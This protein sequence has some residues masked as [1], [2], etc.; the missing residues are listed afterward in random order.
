MSLDHEFI[1]AQ[2]KGSQKL[3]IML[4]G[5]GDS[6]EGFR[7]LPEAMNLP[8]MNY[9]LV[10]A[11]DAYYGGFSWFNFGGDIVPGVQRSRA[12]LGELLDTQRAKGFPTE[13]TILGG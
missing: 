11:P 12:A 6:I 8:D 2:T 5:L 1:A 3:W 7:W 4:H 10:N 9:L 13:Q